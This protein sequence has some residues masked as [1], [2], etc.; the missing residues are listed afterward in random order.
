[1]DSRNLSPFE[2]KNS[3]VLKTVSSQPAQPTSSIKPLNWWYQVATPS[4][5]E[6]KTSFAAQDRL[7]RSRLASLI[8]LLML[9]VL[10]SF[11]RLALLAKN[12]L[13]FPI[14]L[15]AIGICLLALFLNRRGHVTAVG[16]ISVITANTAIMLNLI[17]SPSGM[18]DMNGFLTFDLLVFSELLA[19]SL[20]PPSSVFFVAALNIGCIWGDI[21]LQT[22]AP[23]LEHLWRSMSYTLLVRPIALQIVVAVVTY[24]WV[25][26]ALRAFKRVNRI[27]E[28]ERLQLA[29]A[30]Q[31]RDLEYGI[32]QIQQALVEAANGNFSV[33][34]PLAQENV[35]WTVASSLN[36]LLARLQRSSQSEQELQRIR[37][38][39][40]R[41]VNI[42]S[43]AEVRRVP[44]RLAATGTLLDPL[45]KNLAGRYLLQPASGD[46]PSRP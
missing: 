15:T 3:N 14:I 23:D 1:M 32:Q 38:E 45:L 6:A 46:R 40:L 2:D 20:L 17:T 22:H 35:L 19:V 39:V 8:L 33:R 27:E 25:R 4:E 34:T 43:E 36:T 21:L 31:K 13:L 24:L 7:R 29:L 42:V 44:L 10:V 26:G 30:E 5:T 28:V 9:V 41:L 11:I 18:L 16:I 37:G 12:P